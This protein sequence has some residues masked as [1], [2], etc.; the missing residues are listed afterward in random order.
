[1][2]ALTMALEMRYFT[3]GVSDLHGGL[4]LTGVSRPTDTFYT[5]LYGDDLYDL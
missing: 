5:D 3:R 1:M 4:E 2:V